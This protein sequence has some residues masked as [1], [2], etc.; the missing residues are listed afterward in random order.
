MSI[1]TINPVQIV[2]SPKQMIQLLKDLEQEK[3]MVI[4]LA[5]PTRKGLAHLVDD[6]MR[7]DDV[8]E[9]DFDPNNPITLLSEQI[10][11]PEFLTHERLSIVRAARALVDH[12]DLFVKKLEDND[13]DM[14][15]QDELTA[16]GQNTKDFIALVVD[17]DE[18]ILVPLK[19]FVSEGV[20]VDGEKINLLPVTA[21][22]YEEAVQ[23]LEVISLIRGGL[24]SISSVITDIDFGGEKTGLDLANYIKTELDMPAE[25]IAITS[26]KEEY[27][28]GS[29][30]RQYD[31]SYYMNKPVKHNRLIDHL[32]SKVRAYLR[33]L[34]LIK[35]SEKLKDTI[36]DLQMMNDELAKAN[37]QL[38]NSLIISVIMKEIPVQL[39]DRNLPIGK[40]IEEALNQLHF[41]NPYI[42]GISMWCADKAGGSECKFARTLVSSGIQI[43]DPISDLNE[44]GSIADVIKS[45]QDSIE[46]FY[47]SQDHSELFCEPEFKIRQGTKINVLI[48]E[49]NN[50]VGVLQVLSKKADSHPFS[51]EMI[52]LL[53]IIGLSFYREIENREYANV[54]LAELLK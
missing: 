13:Y 36:E 9:E 23:V 54:Q 44:A 27:P 18:N 51:D 8:N 37:E 22:S 29:V 3:Y 25:I 24:V 49:K 15:P 30:V 35:T 33:N 10:I 43:A 48:K 32:T 2:R 26:K 52:Q 14:Y 6:I 19:S 20:V 21:S 45:G 39:L 46:S 11:P 17:D 42:R 7:L 47:C 16:M 38:K 5:P 50:P 4:P 53:K 34:K 12:Y 1:E 41:Y 40:V 28:E 31:I